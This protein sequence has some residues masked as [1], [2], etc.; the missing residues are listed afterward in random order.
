VSGTVS[1]GNTGA[2]SPQDRVRAL[3]RLANARAKL[4]GLERRDAPAIDP[5][6]QAAVIERQQQIN[7]LRSELGRRGRAGRQAR[8]QIEA[9]EGTQH[10]VMECLG[11]RSFEEFATAVDRFDASRIDHRVLDAAR[12]EVDRAERH[13]FD[14]AEMRIP[15]PSAPGPAAPAG[16]RPAPPHPAPM[17]RPPAPTPLA[18]APRPAPRPA[19]PRWAAG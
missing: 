13:F 9:L 19:P 8:Q 5:E 15:V 3:E 7:G 10:L 11:F 17:S 1:S 14:T 16:R 2:W 18:R 6:I 4:A 12:L